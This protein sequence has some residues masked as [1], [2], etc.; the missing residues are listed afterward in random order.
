V[1]LDLPRV[2]DAEVES[3]EQALAMEGLSAAER[4]PEGG[5]RRILLVEDDDAVAHMV[6]GLLQ[7]SG[8]VCARAASAKEA[9]DMVARDHFDLVFSDI[10]MPGGMSGVD[11]ARDLKRRMPSLPILLT[12]GFAGK[13]HFEA[14]EFEVLHKPWTPEALLAALH[15]KMRPGGDAPESAREP[16][17]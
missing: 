14:G 2:Q 11:L 10:V 6:G 9:L 8:Y 7:A 15:R 3:A 4:L 5:S 13:S 1:H 12:T 17:T 16:F